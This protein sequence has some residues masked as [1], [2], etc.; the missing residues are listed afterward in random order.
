MGRT[1]PASLVGATP[2]HARH[3]MSVLAPPI[4][5]ALHPPAA[6]T[7]EVCATDDLRTG[8]L[9]ALCGIEL[10]SGVELHKDELHLSKQ[11]A[12]IALKA[13]VASVCFECFCC[14]RGML[15]GFRMNVV[16]VD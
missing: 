2:T 8:G 1:L 14:F 12:D 11:Q 13:H 15:H 5:V 9:R 16:K 3:P 6:A 7:A 4:A 10:R